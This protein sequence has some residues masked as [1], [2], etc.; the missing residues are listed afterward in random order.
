[1]H[2]AIHQ[3]RQSAVGADPEDAR[4][5]CKKRLNAAAGDLPP[6]CQPLYALVRVR[7]D[8][9]TFVGDSRALAVQGRQK[10]CSVSG[11]PTL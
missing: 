7:H 2:L 1:M 8:K 11:K 5:V 10:L 6:R 9:H 4:T 3:A